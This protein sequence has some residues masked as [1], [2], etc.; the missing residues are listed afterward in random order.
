[1]ATTQRCGGLGDTERINGI[2]EKL[3]QS[4]KSRCSDSTEEM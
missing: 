2:S 4:L 1:M 3:I